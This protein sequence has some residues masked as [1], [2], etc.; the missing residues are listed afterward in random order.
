MHPVP[1]RNPASVLPWLLLATLLAGCVSGPGLSPEAR[2]ADTLELTATPFH[3]QQRYQ[4]G[5]AALAT[6]LQ[7]SGVATDPEALVDQ[8][9]LPGREGSLQIE[10]VA[11]TRRHGRLAYVL[12]PHPD[13]LLAELKA[14]HPVL[15]MQNLGTGWLPQWH[16]AVVIG[17]DPDDNQVI[18]RSGTTER[19]TERLSAFLRSWALADNWSM[20]ALEPGALPGSRDGRNYLAAVADLEASG[21]HE[22]AAR[23]YRAW[24][25]T[26][27]DN[28]VAHFGL[29]NSLAALQQWHD[30]ASAYEA[31]LERAPADAA[32]LHNL[33]RVEWHR[34]CI[35]RARELARRGS[36]LANESERL[37]EAFTSLQEGLANADADADAACPEGEALAPE[38]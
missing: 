29:G 17:F 18:L 9:W 14:G 12:P 5:P 33:A 37:Q 25:K 32:A 24:L 31:L 11:A 10:L 22:A 34:G 2:P 6:I 27:P 35:V 26:E 4:C 28:L 8:V 15:V 30:A 3:P 16:F 1:S 19:Q 21:Q 20:V 36:L 38:D 7:V 23:A 13:A